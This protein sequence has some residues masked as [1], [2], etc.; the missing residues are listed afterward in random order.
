MPM[1]GLFQS[2]I[3]SPI[4]SP[5][6]SVMGRAAVPTPP[7]SIPT[8]PDTPTSWLYLWET[9]DSNAY[10]LDRM[11]TATLPLR[12]QY[13]AGEIR[14]DGSTTNPALTRFAA[15]GPLGA[16][17]ATLAVFGATSHTLQFVGTD[18][19]DLESG[20][21]YDIEVTMVTAAGTGSKSFRLGQTG[22]VAVHYGLKTVVDEGSASFTT[23]GDSASTH[24]FTFTN[25]IAKVVQIA[26]NAAADAASAVVTADI[27]GTTM[28][29]SAVTSGALLVGSTIAGT[30]VTAGTTIT[31]FG[32]GSGGT[33]TYTV[34]ASQTV[35]S[36]TVTAYV[37]LKIGAVR[38][39]K[40]SDPAFVSIGSQVWGGWAARGTATAGGVV[41]KDGGFDVLGASGAGDGLIAGL[42]GLPATTAFPGKTRLV[43]AKV[44]GGAAAAGYGILA[45]DDFDASVSPSGAYTITSV[46]IEN[47]TQEGYLAFQ[48]NFNVSNHGV[49][50][51]G[52]GYHVFWQR[53]DNVTQEFGVDYYPLREIT[54]TFTAGGTMRRQRIGSYNATRDITHASFRNDY[55]VAAVVLYN[56]KLSQAEM[57]E[58][59]EKAIL[60]FTTDTGQSI[61][62]GEII[63]LIGDS[64][65]TRATNE[66]TSRITAN[67]YFTPAQNVWL[68]M[69]AVGGKGLFEAFGSGFIVDTGA[70]SF[71]TQLAYLMPTLTAAVAAGEHVAVAIRGFT[72]DYVGVTDNR[73]T[74]WD[75]YVSN[76][77]APILATGA[78]LL[79][80][81]VLPSSARFVTADVLWLRSQMAAYAAANVGS[82]WHYASGN[83]GVFDVANM[84]SY[85]AGDNVHLVTTTGDVEV[86]AAYKTLIETWRTER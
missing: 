29:V 59:V 39:K 77:Y 25:D 2:T 47:S 57:L 46:G 69:Q 86:A 71:T 31:A 14:T 78:H 41:Q 83:T 43:I 3:Y 5:I 79:L 19:Y 38:I 10:V 63:G 28:T 35:A 62:D 84:A 1:R 7:P 60:D 64:N 27:S 74:A 70:D 49:N 52:R 81:D 55:E 30:G 24:T 11:G 40:T 34:S 61:G 53:L 65:D 48:P 72:N 17:T 82:V 6:I 73:Q 67:N 80:M 26:P 37:T 22:T 51:I 21:S 76:I 68:S 45:G 54:S 85:F 36:T 15:N 18:T 66:W 44:N 4:V 8:M 12:N 32:T 42:P 58:A 16:N 23:P 33:G 20:V 9:G 56:R 13:G 50:V 75:A